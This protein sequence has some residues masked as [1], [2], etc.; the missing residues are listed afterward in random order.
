MH[1]KSDQILYRFKFLDFIKGEG[2]G[3]NKIGFSSLQFFHVIR[4][5]MANY[6]HGFSFDRMNP[7]EYT[8]R[9]LSGSLT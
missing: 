8:Q 7:Q 6:F 1:L 3:N 9:L 2:N 5:T 4:M